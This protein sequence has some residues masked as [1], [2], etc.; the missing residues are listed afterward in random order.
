MKRYMN[1]LGLG[2]EPTG[3]FLHQVR[4]ASAPEEFFRLC[5][6]HLDHPEPMPLE[7]FVLLLK[8]TDVL[9]GAHL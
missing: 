2:V 5:E 4:R 7:P 8:E 1:F 9:A 6:V 3:Q